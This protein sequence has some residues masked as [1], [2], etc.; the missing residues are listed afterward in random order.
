MKK[1][2]NINDFKEGSLVQGF[3]LCA[4]KNLRYSRTGDLFLDLELRDITGHIS[5]KIWEN[6]DNLDTKIDDDNLKN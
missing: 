1:L 6:V 2:T 5:A 3:F 4:S